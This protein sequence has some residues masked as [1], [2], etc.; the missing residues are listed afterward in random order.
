[1]KPFSSAEITQA[2]NAPFRLVLEHLGA[3]VKVDKDYAPVDR[4]RRSVRLQVA[5]SG[6]DYR[7]VVTGEKFVNE[8]L[9]LDAPNRGGGGTIDLVKHITG[10]G[11]VQAVRVC[12]E[13]IQA[14]QQERGR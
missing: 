9:P 2:R 7:L 14:P 10:I 1:M 13:A 3:Y 6:R 8:L 12:L 11:F 4:S 5:Y